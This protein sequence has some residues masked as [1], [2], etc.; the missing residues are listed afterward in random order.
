M[1][2]TYRCGKCNGPAFSVHTGLLAN[3]GIDL[4]CKVGVICRQCKR[5]VEGASLVDAF[6]AISQKPVPS[7]GKEP[8]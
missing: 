8:K 3:P 1:N 4:T 2:G 6:E 7:E 5:S